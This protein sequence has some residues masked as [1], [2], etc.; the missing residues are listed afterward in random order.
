MAAQGFSMGFMH[1]LVSAGSA[2]L[3]VGINGLGYLTIAGHTAARKLCQFCLMPMTAMISAVNT[4]VSQ[5][6]GAGKRSVY[7]VP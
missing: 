3:Q 4:L 6:Y 1:S 2:I 5:N 7:A